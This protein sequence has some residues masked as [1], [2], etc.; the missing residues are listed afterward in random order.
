MDRHTQKKLICVNLH[1]HLHF[2]AQT[3]MRA[4]KMIDQKKKKKRKKCPIN[5]NKCTKECF[6]LCLLLGI[7]KTETTFNH[8]VYTIFEFKCVLTYI[9]NQNVLFTA[10]YIKQDGIEKQRQLFC[11]RHFFSL[12]L[13][14]IQQLR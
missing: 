4:N 2:C 14:F 3:H 13:F 7:S 12:F 8:A 1:S 6:F 11:G 9:L 5:K 10:F